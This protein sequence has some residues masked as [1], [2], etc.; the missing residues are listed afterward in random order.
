M[1]LPLAQP[2]HDQAQDNDEEASA[3][4]RTHSFFTFLSLVG[5][6][7]VVLHGRALF[8]AVSAGPD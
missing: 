6:F 1:Q 3:T 2:D 4:H 7:P 5:R 8:P